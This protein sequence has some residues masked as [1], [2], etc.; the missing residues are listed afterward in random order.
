MFKLEFP[1]GNKTLAAAIGRALVEYS[2]GTVTAG[3]TV[4]HTVKTEVGDVSVTE[5]V[6]TEAPQTAEVE[7]TAELAR[8]FN[9][10]SETAPTKAAGTAG[11]KTDRNNLDDKGVGKNPDFCGNAQIPFNQSGKKKG[12]WKKKAGV[13]EKLY[14]KW[15]AGELAQVSQQDQDNADSIGANAPVNT[16]AAF[17]GKDTPETVDKT[18]N[19]AGEFMA[20]IAEQQAA[21]LLTQGDIDSAYQMTSTQ[22]HDLFNP[23]LFADAVAAVYGFLAPIAAAEA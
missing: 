22:V 13:D 7:D 14:D 3:A 17:G 12:Q 9:E 1:S 5:T 4:T 11:D 18:F 16:G 20:W 15:Y 6:Q 19:D 21:E 23:A 8:V 10:V 2:G